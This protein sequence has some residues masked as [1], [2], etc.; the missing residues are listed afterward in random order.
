[1]ASKLIDHLHNIFYNTLMNSKNNLP[2]RIQKLDRRMNGYGVFSHR[3]TFRQGHHFPS[4]YKSFLITRQWF[5]ENI[6]QG[7]ELGMFDIAKEAEL[8]CTWA[9]DS[10]NYRLELFVSERELSALIMHFPVDNSAE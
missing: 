8:N 5:F 10:N 2:F 7:C 9:W 3:L 1:M 4:C 6:G